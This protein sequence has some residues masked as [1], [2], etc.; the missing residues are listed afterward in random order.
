LEQLE[1]NL[2]DKQLIVEEYKQYKVELEEY[3]KLLA[4]LPIRLYKYLYII[5]CFKIK[6]IMF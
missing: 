5:I 1:G 4:T 3:N 6:A 2:K